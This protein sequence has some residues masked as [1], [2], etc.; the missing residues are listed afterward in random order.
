MVLEKTVFGMAALV[1]RLSVASHTRSGGLWTA[2]RRVPAGREAEMIE[3]ARL[4]L[5]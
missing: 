4:F 2:Q 1:D 3:M 5:R